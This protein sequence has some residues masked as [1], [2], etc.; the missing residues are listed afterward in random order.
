[1]IPP[2]LVFILSTEDI[3][4]SVVFMSIITLSPGADRHADRRVCTVYLWHTALSIPRPYST[5]QMIELP[6]VH[7]DVT[8]F[9]SHE[10]HVSGKCLG[11]IPYC[12]QGIQKA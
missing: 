6:P 7:M 2:G 4:G 9:V 3:M 5:P 12:V 8:H 11:E 10:P 1:M